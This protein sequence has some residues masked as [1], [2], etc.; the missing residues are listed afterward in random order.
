MTKLAVDY[1]TRNP[2]GRTRP[3]GIWVNCI[4][5]GLIDMPIHAT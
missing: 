1:L 2:G 5:P 3:P 4:A